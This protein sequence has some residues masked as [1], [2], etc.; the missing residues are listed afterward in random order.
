MQRTMWSAE[1]SCQAAK[2]LATEHKR[3]QKFGFRPRK[4]ILEI[5]LFYEKRRQKFRLIWHKNLRRSVQLCCG[6]EQ[7]HNALPK[8]PLL[9]EIQFNTKT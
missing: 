4:I 6:N 7:V 5:S 8:I 2:I 1:Q 9:K 3:G